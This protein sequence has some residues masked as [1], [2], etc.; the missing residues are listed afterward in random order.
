MA[1]IDVGQAGHQAQRGQRIGGE[2]AAHVVVQ[3]P[4]MGNFAQC[5]VQGPAHA[6][7]AVGRSQAT[8]APAAGVIG[9]G[10]RQVNENV[11]TLVV[12]LAIQPAGHGRAGNN[13]HGHF[14]RQIQAAP[15]GIGP[16]TQ[17]IDD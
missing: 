1:V 7:G 4:G 9:V 3:A 6:V 14:I 13:G 5:R 16:E 2:A 15:V 10:Q 11:A 8:D 12:G 17:V